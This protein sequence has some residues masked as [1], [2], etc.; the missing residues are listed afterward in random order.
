MLVDIRV[1]VGRPLPEVAEFAARCEDAG[2]HGVGIHDHPHSGRDVYLA[3]ALAAQ[4]TRRL[5]LYPATSSPVVRHPVLL[6]SAAHSLEEVAPGRVHLTV[7]PGF[8]AARSVG[9]PRATVAAM[10]EAVSAIRRLLR[11]ETVAVGEGTSRLRN[12]SAHPTPVYV[13]AAGPRMVELAGEVADGAVLMVGL[14]P[15]AIAAARRHLAEGARRA[16]RS[17]DGFP[18]VFIATI[19]L[20]PAREVARRWIRGWFAPGQPFLAYPN[21]SNLHW[22]REAGVAPPDPLAPEAIPDDL[23]AGIADAFGL[24]GPAEHCLERLLRA[25]AEASVDRVFLFPA[26]TLE[27]GYDMPEAEVE[28]F[29]RVIGPGLR[30]A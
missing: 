27:G 11:G 17:L 21:A 1:P 23:A 24:F 15:A 18:V 13:L 16:G 7:A 2:F 26:H 4:R 14:H 8:L 6:A 25:R 30:R 12:V 22:L 28:A 9:R 29:A 3:L 19:A 5:A 20:G 10:R